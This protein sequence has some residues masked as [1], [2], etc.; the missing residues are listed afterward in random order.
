MIQRFLEVLFPELQRSYIEL[1][2]IKGPHQVK[3]SFHPAISEFLQAVPKTLHDQAEH[4]V[5]FG[6]SPSARQEGTKQA[7]QQV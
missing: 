4:N 2:L 7:V 6:V 5:Y 1:R 3:A